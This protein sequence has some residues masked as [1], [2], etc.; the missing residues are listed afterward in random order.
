MLG[1]LIAKLAAL[2][3]DP[4]EIVIGDVRWWFVWWRWW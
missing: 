2:P 1:S 4:P 3:F